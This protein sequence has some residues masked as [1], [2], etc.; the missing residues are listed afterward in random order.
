MFNNIFVGNH[1]G[2]FSLIFAGERARDNR[3]DS[4]VYVT[5]VPFERQYAINLTAGGNTVA[6]IQKAYGEG[7]KRANRDNG[8]LATLEPFPE[9]VEVT[10]EQWRYILGCDLKSAVLRH[11]EV[12]HTLNSA[13]LEFSFK[14]S[15]ALFQVACEPMQSLDK[16]FFGN[17]INRA[18]IIPGPF[19]NLKEGENVFALCRPLCLSI[20]KRTD[21]NS[22]SYAR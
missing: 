21:K 22:E 9:G 11:G 16:D 2:A 12:T 15:A 5:Y 10:L 14:T 4:N 19:Q 1:R 7:A 3:S 6:D 8:L 13:F 17:P 20:L 18:R